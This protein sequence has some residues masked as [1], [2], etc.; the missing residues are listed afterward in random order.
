V[1]TASIR[2]QCPLPWSERYPLPLEKVGRRS[3]IRSAPSPRIVLQALA[4]ASWPRWPRTQS[5]LPRRPTRPRPSQCAHE[6]RLD[7]PAREPS[8]LPPLA[9]G[10]PPFPFAYGATIT[11]CPTCIGSRVQLFPGGP[12]GASLRCRWA[13]GWGLHAGSRRWLPC[14]CERLTIRPPRGLCRGSGAVTGTRWAATG[15]PR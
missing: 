6:I 12:N 14:R 4:V 9:W 2:P 15:C 1:T 3:R 5:M 11:S 13:P 7:L 8:R 10:G